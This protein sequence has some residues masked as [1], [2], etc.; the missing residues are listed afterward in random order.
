MFVGARV[1]KPKPKST[2]KQ[3]ISTKPKAVDHT[4]SLPPSEEGHRDNTFR[5]FR[6][7][8]MNVADA[9]SYLTKTAIIK[10]MFTKGTSGGNVYFLFTL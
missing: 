9:S 3:Q 4:V 7:L 1:K 2:T 10:E 8:C 6:K 5:E